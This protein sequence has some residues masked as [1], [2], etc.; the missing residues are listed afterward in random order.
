M[1][2]TVD[3]TPYA[4]LHDM[5][6]E[7][8]QA[9]AATQDVQR[10]TSIQLQQMQQ[11]F[12][13]ESWA[14]QQRA[15]QEARAEDYQRSLQMAQAK[16]EIDLQGELRMYTQKRDQFM[17]DVSQIQE[18]DF[19]ND[20]DKERLQKKAYAKYFGVADSTS[21]EDYFVKQKAKQQQVRNLQEQVAAGTMTADVARGEATALG[22][23]Q[24]AR[25]FETPE[26]IA[27]KKLKP[28]LTEQRQLRAEIR[29]NFQINNRGWGKNNLWVKDP[30]EREWV[31][32]TKE[33]EAEHKAMLQ[34]LLTVTQKISDLEDVAP[35]L[36]SDSG[37]P[38]LSDIDMM[39][40]PFDEDTEKRLKREEKQKSLEKKQKNV[41]T[42]VG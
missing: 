13:K 10:S 1:P 23:P 2:I 38:S 31:E 41:A 37:R 18:A 36:G 8:G 4:A 25:L 35:G 7:A 21:L 11:D 22:V 16:Q 39:G 19:L 9:R 17:S 30:V 6:T 32:A 26:Q 34:R 15:E 5:S 3:Y 29:A 40:D 12:Q 33:E 24:S 28:L 27:T 14:F 42:W 20:E